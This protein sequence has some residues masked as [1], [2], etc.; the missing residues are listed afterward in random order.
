VA[1]EPTARIELPTADADWV[2]VRPP[3]VF[4]RSLSGLEV[5]LGPFLG[6]PAE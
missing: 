5:V 6:V 2:M 4:A 1:R 3:S